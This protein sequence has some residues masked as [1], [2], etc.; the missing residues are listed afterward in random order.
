MLRQA[1]CLVV[2][3]VAVGGFA[4]LFDCRLVGWAL[5][6]VA[7][8]DLGTCLM[9]R[10]WGPGALAVV[11]PAGVCLLNFFCSC[12]RFYLLLGPCLC[13]ISF[14]YLNLY[15][16]GLVR[17]WVWGLLCGRGICVSWSASG[18]GVG[19]VRRWAL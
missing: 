2:G 1:A 15:V 9:M 10:C 13:F 16:L 5:G 18:L 11:G 19:S 3:P 14:L 6:S 4:F 12:V 8:I 7:G 17:W